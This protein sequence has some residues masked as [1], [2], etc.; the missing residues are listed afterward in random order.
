MRVFEA[1]VR[2]DR[3]W[4]TTNGPA[5]WG[6]RRPMQFTEKLVMMINQISRFFAHEG[7]ERAPVSIADHLCKYWE[8]RMRTAI[9]KHVANGGQA[10]DPL[11]LTA[12]KQLDN[13]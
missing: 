13:K 1:A 10:L 11:A 12:V 4:L 5:P 8:P 7:P 9:K 3:M 2:G 6:I